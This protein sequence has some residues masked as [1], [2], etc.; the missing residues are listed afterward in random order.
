MRVR[1]ERIQRVQF[2]TSAFSAGAKTSHPAPPA[3][4]AIPSQ[5]RSGRRSEFQSYPRE[6]GE[7]WR[8]EKRAA[9]REAA[10]RRISQKSKKSAGSSITSGPRS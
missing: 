4:S 7:Q 10:S 1:G 5:P 2:P 9:M 3:R 6:D 8:E